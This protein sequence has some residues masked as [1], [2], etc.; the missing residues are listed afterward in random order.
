MLGHVLG[1]DVVDEG[2]AHVGD[3]LGD[4]FVLHQV[5]ALVEDD[6][7]LVVLDVVEFQQ[8][9]AD[10]EV[11]RLDLLLRL[12]QRLVDPGMDDGLALFQAERCSMVSS[13]SEPKIRIRS[14]S[15][16]RK[17]FERPGSP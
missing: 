15:S 9:L 8:I 11:A 14:S 5:D 6:L 16:D 4:A 3:G 12:L 17:N 13:R 10:V 7:A 1:D 2:V